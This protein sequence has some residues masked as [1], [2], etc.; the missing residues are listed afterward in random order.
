MCV[1][2][3]PAIVQL[4][5]SWA[6]CMLAPQQRINHNNNDI[7]Q[8]LG[9]RLYDINP[10]CISTMHIGKSG[11]GSTLLSEL[12]DRMVIRSHSHHAVMYEK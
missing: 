2:A 3:I 12:T 11:K 6:I 1:K 5:T 10:V 8:L 9:R 4:S 7:I